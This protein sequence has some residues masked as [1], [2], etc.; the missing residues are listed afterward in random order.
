MLVGECA[1][2]DPGELAVADGDLAAGA[3]LPLA[4]ID[5]RNWNDD[6]AVDESL[7]PT[8]SAVQDAVVLNGP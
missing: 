8:E 1:G 3:M 4:D 2:R 5:L 7:L 6:V